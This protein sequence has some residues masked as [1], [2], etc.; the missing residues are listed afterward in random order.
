MLGMDPLSSY[1]GCHFSGAL[2]D[3][4]EFMNYTGHL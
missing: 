2:F 1:V 4:T 3:Y